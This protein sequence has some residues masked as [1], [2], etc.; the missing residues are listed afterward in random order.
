[1][2]MPIQLGILLLLLV[3]GHW[4][5]AA[6]GQTLGALQVSAVSSTNN[7]RLRE[8][9]H[10][11]LRV[12]NPT[13]TNQTISVM[14]CSWDEEWKSSNTNVGI[15]GWDCTKNNMHK[16]ILPPGGAYTNEATMMIFNLIADTNLSFRMGFTSIGS[17]Q[18]FWSGQIQ[19]RILPPDTWTRGAQFYRDRNH[20]G[21]IDWEVS[22]KTWMGHAVDP[23][24]MIDAG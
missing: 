16:I 20:D 3:A 9:F 7:I 22:G 1:M 14:T 4:A 5:S 21:K 12:A 8:P 24:K 2:K 6:E 17:T 19:L 23:L 13:A 11:T 18:T 15:L 10:M